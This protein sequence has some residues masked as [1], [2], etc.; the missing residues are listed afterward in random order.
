MRTMIWVAAGAIG[1]LAGGAAGMVLPSLQI[2]QAARQFSNDFAVTPLAALNPIRAA[3]DTVK[4]SIQ[5]GMTPDQLGF[6]AA[7]PLVL[8]MP[9]PNKWQGVALTLSPGM[10]KGWAT[11]DAQA[12]QFNNRMQ[13]MRTYARNPAGWRGAPPL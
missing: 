2:S 10:Q 8:T 4:A 7:S 1:A 6:H 5:T 13:D 9:D 3:Y 11:V 12:R